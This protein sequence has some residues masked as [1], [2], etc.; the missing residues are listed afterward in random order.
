MKKSIV[1]LIIGASFLGVML[2]QTAQADVTGNLF[3]RTIQWADGTSERVQIDRDCYF[4]LNGRKVRLVGIDLGA[5]GMSNEFFKP[6]SLAIFDKELA[7]LASAGIRLIHVNFGYAGY[8]REAERYSGLLDLLYRHKMLVFPLISGKWLPNFGSLT[9]ADF[10][11]GGSDSL[12][13]WATRWCAIM[14]NYPNVVA[15][16]AENELDIPLKPP[17]VPVL[18]EYTGAETAAY[19]K[20]LTSI[21]R[22]KLHVPVVTK[23]VGEVNA[24]WPWRPDIKEAVLPFSDTPCLDLYYPTVREMEIHLEA[25]LNWL[26]EK[27]AKTN[28]VWIGEANAGTGA[29]PRCADFSASYVGSMFDHGAAVVCLWVANRVKNPAWAFFDS[30]GNPGETLLRMAPDLKRLQAPIS[31][32]PA[33]SK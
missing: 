8:K 28:G 18:Q 24:S 22:S 14:T 31:E 1:L 13:Q 10:V 15:V 2:P 29:A 7:Y 4:R 19:M 9:N 32:S 30:D 16:A 3:D 25:V 33:V 21:I 17:T 6:A 26:K 12:G 27:G 20:F 11:I 5:T 23:L